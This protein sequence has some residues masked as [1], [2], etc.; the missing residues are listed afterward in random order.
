[1]TGLFLLSASYSFLLLYTNVIDNRFNTLLLCVGI[2]W[3]YSIYLYEKIPYS[4]RYLNSLTVEVE[5]TK[6]K[7]I[8][9][10]FLKRFLKRPKVTLCDFLQRKE[11]F[12]SIHLV[13]L[14]CFIARLPYYQGREFKLLIFRFNKKKIS[15]F[16]MHLKRKL[17]FIYHCP[18][19]WIPINLKRDRYNM[20]A[21]IL[22]VILLKV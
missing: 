16:E 2:M 1:M 11:N 5:K 4:A 3:S 14:Q 19:S 7:S 17:F 10:E 9:K 15:F 13:F 6:I 8:L 12:R 18:L 22:R 21:L 20:G